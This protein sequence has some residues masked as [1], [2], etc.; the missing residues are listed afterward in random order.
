[1][2]VDAFGARITAACHA[3]GLPTPHHARP[4]TG[5]TANVSFVVH[6]QDPVILTFCV[7]L[8]EAQAARLAALLQ[9]LAAHGLP[10]NVVRSTTDGRSCVVIDDV[11]VIAKAF[12]AGRTLSQ[13]DPVRANHI[14][15]LLAQLHQVSAPDWLPRDHGMNRGAMS[16]MGNSATE[17]DF[18]E[19]IAH[20][21]GRLPPSW[22]HLPHGMVHGDLFPDNILER[23][24]GALVAIDFEEACVQPLAFDL[25]MTLVGFA[26]VNSLSDDTRDALITGYQRV[27]PLTTQEREALPHLFDYAAAITACWRYEL[28]HRGGPPGPHLRDWRDMQ[29]FH[30]SLD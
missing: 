14:G 26:H 9:H 1:M 20:A 13:V 29:G 21:L 19:W 2:S 24:D 23:P 18:A 25:G 22:D 27:R 11:P 3:Y 4:L 5:G 15:A 28:S 6:P 16:A 7:D 8:V 10:T 12:V 17:T 30:G